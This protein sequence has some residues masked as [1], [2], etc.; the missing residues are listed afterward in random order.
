MTLN[1]FL[2]ISVL[3]VC[4]LHF[5]DLRARFQYVL[6]QTAGHLVLKMIGT[7]ALE[8][9]LAAFLSLALIVPGIIFAVRWFLYPPV[10]VFEGA[11][12]MDA[13]KRSSSLVRGQWWRLFGLSLVF[14]VVYILSSGVLYLVTTLGIDEVYSS[15][16]TIVFGSIVLPIGAIL[17]FLFYVDVRVR[18]EGLTL[19]M[20]QESIDLT[21]SL[22][23]WKF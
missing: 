5:V 20:L 14:I 9:I 7:T 23:G 10:I 16:I 11:Y 2:T 17:V 3:I 8:C 21:G 13:L 18:K 1:C 12:Y 6:S 15:A 4:L 19:E 22:T